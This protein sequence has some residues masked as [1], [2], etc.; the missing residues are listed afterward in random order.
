MLAALLPLLMKG[1]GRAVPGLF[2]ALAPG[3]GPRGRRRRRRS[4]VTASQLRDLTAIKNILGKTAAAEAMHLL[5]R[6]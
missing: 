5:V 6:R 4:L 2:G 3:L 1:A